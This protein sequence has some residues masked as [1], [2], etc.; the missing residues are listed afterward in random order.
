[1]RVGDKEETEEVNIYLHQ[2]VQGRGE[3][4]EKGGGVIADR[5][6]FKCNQHLLP[7]RKKRN[8]LVRSHSHTHHC[9][10]QRYAALA[11]AQQAKVISLKVFTQHISAS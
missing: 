7:R 8:T 3:R 1:M 9:C 10:V 11:G 5:K 6:L 2:V 4:G